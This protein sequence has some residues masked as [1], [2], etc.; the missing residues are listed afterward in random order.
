MYTSLR[1]VLIA[2]RFSVAMLFI[3]LTVL[4]ISP[5]S[6]VQAQ[7]SGQK[8]QQPKQPDQAAPDSGGP[9]GDTG[10]I[11]VPRKKDV[12]EEAPP[13]PAPAA[14]GKTPPSPDKAR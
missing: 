8:S 6:Q 9:G 7:S 1:P 12:P 2:R 4:A 14:A 3:A 10:V 11:A 13:P 5:S